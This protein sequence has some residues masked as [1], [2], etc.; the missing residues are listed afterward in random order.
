MSKPATII[1][2]WHE[3]SRLVM[4]AGQQQAP[5]AQLAD[6][7]TVQNYG[8]F[9][10]HYASLGVEIY[11]P[12]SS[13]S[14]ALAPASTTDNEIA[15]GDTVAVSIDVTS[16]GSAPGDYELVAGFNS[17]GLDGTGAETSGTWCEILY[18]RRALTTRRDQAGNT[19]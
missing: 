12:D 4:A 11:A 15:P 3:E 9:T 8:E 10:A 2:R 1:K 14:V 7:Y 5:G 18:P 19:F 16:F 17:V 6:T 13:Q